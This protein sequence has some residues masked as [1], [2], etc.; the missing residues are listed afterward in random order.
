MMDYQRHNRVKETHGRK[1]AEHLN[2]MVLLWSSVVT[3]SIL[4]VSV[5]Q[6]LILK[7]LFDGI[8]NGRGK[9]PKLRSFIM[10][11]YH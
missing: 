4:L 11:D 8:I 6:V 2:Y 3:I 10:S 5:V 7:K 9:E 1:R